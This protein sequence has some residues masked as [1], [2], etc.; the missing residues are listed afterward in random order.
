MSLTTTVN[1]ITSE[2]FFAKLE[3]SAP[4][5][6]QG[7]ANMDLYVLNSE[8]GQQEILISIEGQYKLINTSART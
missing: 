3:A 7:A 1:T 4:I 6:S 5:K 8:P 2:V